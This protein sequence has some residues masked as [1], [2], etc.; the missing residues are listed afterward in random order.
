MSGYVPQTGEK[1][2]AKLVVA[3]QNLYQGR[4]N[5]VGTF[6]ITANATTT[7]VTAPNCTVSSYVHIQPQT[8]HAAW[9]KATTYVTPGNGQFVVTHASNPNND[10]TFGFVAIG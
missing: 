2:S 8:Q 1:D 10:C 9:H 6:T 5:A 4:S 3:I 7:T